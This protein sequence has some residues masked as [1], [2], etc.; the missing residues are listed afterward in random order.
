MFTK[1]KMLILLIAI[2]SVVAA[3]E[4][5]PFHELKCSKYTYQYSPIAFYGKIDDLTGKNYYPFED[6]FKPQGVSTF[7]HTRVACINDD[8]TYTIKAYDN[9]YKLRLSDAKFHKFFYRY[10]SHTL[11]FGPINLNVTNSVVKC[12]LK[13]GGLSTPVTFIDGIAF[14]YDSYCDGVAFFQMCKWWARILMPTSQYTIYC[15]IED[16]LYYNFKAPIKHMSMA[17]ST[18]YIEYVFN[19]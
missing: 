17:G 3:K 11:L 6:D 12:T 15:P 5:H 10:F 2:T 16:E 9:E 13:G 19:P 1:L 18:G 4:L 7:P 14:L 8:E